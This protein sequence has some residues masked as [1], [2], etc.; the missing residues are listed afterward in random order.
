M[1]GPVTEGK[2]SGPEGERGRRDGGGPGRRGRAARGRTG[3]R[4][5]PGGDRVR[6]P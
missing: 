3:F 6:F 5:P 4:I 1:C 2:H